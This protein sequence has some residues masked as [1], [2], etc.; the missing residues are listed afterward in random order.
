MAV[1]ETSPNRSTK[2]L[3]LPST[4]LASW[5]DMEKDTVESGVGDGDGVGVGDG[6]GPP[7]KSRAKLWRAMP[8]TELKLPPRTILLSGC[9]ARVKTV[10]LVPVPGLKPVSRLPSA[11]IRAM[12]LRG[13]PLK[14]ENKPPMTIL[15]SGCSAK[16]KTEPASVP[17]PVLKEL[18]R[19]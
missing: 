17:L 8:L 9:R 2:I 1:L 7:P 15:P 6:V 16:L 3:I 13:A 12:L 11:L 18:S 14:A 5:T 10:L 19:L 4:S